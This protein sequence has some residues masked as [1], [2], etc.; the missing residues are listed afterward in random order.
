MPYQST[1]AAIQS[2]EYYGQYREK[3]LIRK[4]TEILKNKTDYLSNPNFSE[5]ISRD[6]NGT[7][8]SFADPLAFG[9]ADEELYELVTIELRQRNFNR[10][11]LN[12]LNNEDNDFTFFT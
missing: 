4:R 7:L 5:T 10:T 2:S 8:I 9:K 6:K 1:D 12:K 3:E 11:F